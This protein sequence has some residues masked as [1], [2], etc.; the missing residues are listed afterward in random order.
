MTIKKCDICGK[1]MQEHES[2]SVKIEAQGSVYL[3]ELQT[4]AEYDLCKECT[5]DLKEVIAGMRSI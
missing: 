2:V 1:E 3:Y 5:A 4:D